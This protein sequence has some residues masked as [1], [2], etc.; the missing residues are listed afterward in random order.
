[1]AD[2]LYYYYLDEE[3]RICGPHRLEDLQALL[4][5]GKI[6]LGTRAAAYRDKEWTVVAALLA[7]VPGAVPNYVN[8]ELCGA[9]IALVQGALPKE[10]PECHGKLMPGGKSLWSHFLYCM[11]ERFFALRGRATRREYWGWVLWITLLQLL[12]ALLIAG[13]TGYAMFRY[14]QLDSIALGI[15]LTGHLLMGITMLFFSFPYYSLLVRRL[16][17]IGR[18]GKWALIILAVNV[19]YV[20]YTIR[21]AIHS[22]LSLSEWHMVD[23]QEG[24]QHFILNWSM[25][26]PPMTLT[27][28]SLELLFYLAALV[29]IIVACTNSRRGSNKYG[30][31][32]KYPLG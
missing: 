21:A 29:T 32:R 1:M 31:S 20:V 22:A 8:C 27:Y 30:P 13:G 24:M 2:S 10:C 11:N 5:E 9:G 28:L 19:S 25:A 7:R 17:D 23:A 4:V 26:E 6:S 3:N 16:H 15:L 14:G 12:V 18:S